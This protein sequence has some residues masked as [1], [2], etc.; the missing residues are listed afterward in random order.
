GTIALGIY[1]INVVD[2]NSTLISMTS[3]S[4]LNS[5]TSFTTTTESG[6]T[7]SF[8][9]YQVS[10]NSISA[11][12]NNAYNFNVNYTSSVDR[13]G[14]VGFDVTTTENIKL[15]FS[16][17]GVNYSSIASWDISDK[18]PFEGAFQ[19]ILI[20]SLTTYFLRLATTV[21]VTLQRT[22]FTASYGTASES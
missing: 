17:D 22:S 13:G 5:T 11:S 16:T 8:N 3:A 21:G 12:Y 4:N 20:T 9:S 19:Y 6:Q 7:S 1:S 18:P 14:Y 2:N 10:L 15:Y